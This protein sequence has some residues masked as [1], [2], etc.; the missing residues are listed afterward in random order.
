MNEEKTK[1][2]AQTKP[3]EDVG[4][5][6]SINNT[7]YLNTSSN[8]QSVNIE[9]GQNVN[10][11]NSSFDMKG[12]IEM[13]NKKINNISF[14]NNN[15][16]SNNNEANQMEMEDILLKMVLEEGEQKKTLQL[17]E[18]NNNNILNENNYVANRL[19]TSFENNRK[20][21]VLD[22]SRI[23][24]QPKKNRDENSRI[25]ASFEKNS[26]FVNVNNESRMDK[27]F[28]IGCCAHEEE[29]K[30]AKQKIDHLNKKMKLITEENKVFENFFTI[31]FIYFR[32]LN[33]CWKM[34]RKK[35][36][37]VN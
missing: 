7:L 24:E 36:I 5:R 19:N 37:V 2:K 32:Y 6:I 14:L 1:N 31:S 13:L 12:D 27:T 3:K 4:P 34:K 35:T 25:N 33:H 20:K 21:Q 18:T 8:Y 9:N 23:E 16:H 15:K 28:N 11:I 17:Q 30:K 26:S 10:N 29:L 22:K